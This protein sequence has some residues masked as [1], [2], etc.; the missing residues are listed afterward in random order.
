MTYGLQVLSSSGSIIIDTTTNMTRILGVVD[1]M[2]SSSLSGTVTD[3]RFSTGRL[4]TF[5][6]PKVIGTNEF[7]KPI[8]ALLTTSIT[9][10]TLTWT[11]D[12]QGMGLVNAGSLIYGVF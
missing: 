3:S 9:G 4:F 7:S 2:G 12:T 11:V 10:S 6:S 8:L 1:S 5:F